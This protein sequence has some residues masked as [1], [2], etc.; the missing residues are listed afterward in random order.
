MDDSFVCVGS[1]IVDS[2][3]LLL[4]LMM[5]SCRQSAGGGAVL[6]VPM[7]DVGW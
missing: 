1:S 6:L 3:R 2:V 4:L 7:M 5:L